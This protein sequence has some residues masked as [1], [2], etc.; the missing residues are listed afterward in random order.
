MK[1]KFKLQALLLLKKQKQ[2]QALLLYARTMQQVNT[3]YK[4]YQQLREKLRACEAWVVEDKAFSCQQHILH[5]QQLEYLNASV[6]SVKQHL[7]VLKEEEKKRLDHFLE[8]KKDVAALERIKEKQRIK[9]LKELE[10]NESK[11]RDEW[12]QGYYRKII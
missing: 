10:A 5:L 3:I 12:A 11:E 7:D 8:M 6:K 9:I 4:K 2:E 1:L